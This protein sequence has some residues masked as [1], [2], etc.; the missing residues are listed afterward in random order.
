MR[1]YSEITKKS[2]YTFFE[3]V[4]IFFLLCI[5]VCTCFFFLME[6]KERV[7]LFLCQAKGKRGRLVPQELWPLNLFFKPLKLSLKGFIQKRLLL[8][9]SRECGL[10]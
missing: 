5:S 6:E 2:I 1:S 9:V 3:N 7:A 4:Y 8:P 10:R